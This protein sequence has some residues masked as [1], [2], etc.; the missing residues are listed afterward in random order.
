MPRIPGDLPAQWPERA[1]FLHQYGDP[2]SARLWQI[3][4]AELERALEALGEETLSLAEAA[5]VSGYTADHLGGLVKRGI[6][7]NAGRRGAPRIRR[8]DLP[9][10][11]P[12]GPGRRFEILAAH[13]GLP[14]VRVDL[15]RP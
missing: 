4:A 10:K 3:A 8:Q 13:W 5:R 7:P 11:K 1:G 2:D 15:T 6:I 9:S 12:N 14:I